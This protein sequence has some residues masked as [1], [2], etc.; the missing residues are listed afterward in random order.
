MC[1]KVF[2]QRQEALA[3]P[4][5]DVVTLREPILFYQ[6]LEP[7]VDDIADPNRLGDF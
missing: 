1:H 6:L 3:N 5:I 2:M 7:E 4:R